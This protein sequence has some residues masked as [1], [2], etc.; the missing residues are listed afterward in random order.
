V[1]L[2]RL[3]IETDAPDQLLPDSE[4]HFPL[5][6][7]AGKSINHPANLVAV[8][9]FVARERGMSVQSFADQSRKIF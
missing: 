4:N 8:Y 2:D 1:P 3:L 7:S 5:R 6:D 9:E